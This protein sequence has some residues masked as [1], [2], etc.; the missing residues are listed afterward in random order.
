[1]VAEPPPLVPAIALVQGSSMRIEV[2]AAPTH[3]R[4]RDC[5]QETAACESRLLLPQRW[6][7]RSNSAPWC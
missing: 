5:P 7:G 2:T 4:V 6:T 3:D 1:M